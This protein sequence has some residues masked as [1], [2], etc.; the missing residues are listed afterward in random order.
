MHTDQDLRPALIGSQATPAGQFLRYELDVELSDLST[1]TQIHVHPPA[2]SDQEKRSY[3]LMRRTNEISMVTI[4][5]RASPCLDIGHVLMTCF[6]CPKRKQPDL[7][8]R[9]TRVHHHAPE[10]QSH[11]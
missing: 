4:R 5:N 7:W 10:S 11:L 8:L 1:I 9:Q 6:H 3:N 2:S